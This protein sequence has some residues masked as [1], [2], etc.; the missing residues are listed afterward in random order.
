VS[1]ADDVCT[2][3]SVG[4]TVEAS[5]TGAVEVIAGASVGGRLGA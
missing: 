3:E 4:A 1:G 5:G 2:G